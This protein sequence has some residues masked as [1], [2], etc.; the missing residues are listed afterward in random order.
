MRRGRL[1]AILNVIFLVGGLACLAYGIR[2]TEALIETREGAFIGGVLILLA[3]ISGLF[4]ATLFRR[5]ARLLTENLRLATESGRMLPLE[6]TDGE[7]MPLVTSVN[8]L[9]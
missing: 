9:V 8:Q 5:Q 2:L 1:L 7:L 3:G 4:A 6:A